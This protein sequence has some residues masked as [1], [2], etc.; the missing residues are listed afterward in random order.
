MIFTVHLCVLAVRGP[1]GVRCL[2]AIAFR[3]L[4]VKSRA[5][6]LPNGLHLRFRLSLD[7]PVA[8]IGPEG[9][10]EV[11]CR[12]RASTV[13]APL[14]AVAVGTLRAIVD[15]PS[16]GVLPGAAEPAS[17]LPGTGLLVMVVPAILTLRDS[18]FVRFADNGTS[19]PEEGDPS[20][21]SV[22]GVFL[23]G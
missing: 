21:H 23:D 20:W 4:I 9:A 13:G 2:R 6:C 10:P 22:R 5:L 14:W 12:V 1:A 18:G 19:C 8:V 7:A 3:L 16:F 11:I 15:M 17:R